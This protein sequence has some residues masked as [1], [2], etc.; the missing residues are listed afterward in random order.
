M[1]SEELGVVRDEGGEKSDSPCGE[2]ARHPRREEGVMGLAA[3]D[4]NEFI[5]F[6]FIKIIILSIKTLNFAPDD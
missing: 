6:F 1:K 2:T 3:N 5:V 4:C